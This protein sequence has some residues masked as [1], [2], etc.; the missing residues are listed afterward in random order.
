M[1]RVAKKSESIQTCGIQLRF[2]FSLLIFGCLKSPTVLQ[3]E[4]QLNSKAANLRAEYTRLRN[5]DPENDDPIYLNQWQ[6]LRSK[7][8]AYLAKDLGT[9]ESVRIRTD[10]ADLNLRLWRITKSEGLLTDARQILQPLVNLGGDKQSSDFYESCIL[11]GDLAVAAKESLSVA[12]SWYEKAFGGGT[13]IRTKAEQRL[14]SSTIA[15]SSSATMATRR[16]VTPSA[17]RRPVR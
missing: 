5:I 12:R 10:A 2:L 7:F 13:I 11:R 14:T 16:S 8:N 1:S 9:P 3:A 15:S 6:E 17:R 4:P